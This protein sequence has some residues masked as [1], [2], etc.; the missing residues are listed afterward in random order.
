MD[1]PEFFWISS[2]P[3]SEVWFKEITRNLETNR[4]VDILNRKLDYCLQVQSTLQDL[5]ST[6]SAYLTYLPHYLWIT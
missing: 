5:E 4:R 6:V 2:N 3:L 1:M